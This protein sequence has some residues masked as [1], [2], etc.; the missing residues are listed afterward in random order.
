MQFFCLHILN[1]QNEITGG[2]FLATAKLGVTAA[3]CL[4]DVAIEGEEFWIECPKSGDK[5]KAVVREIDQQ[6]DL[7]VIELLSV[8]S[9]EIPPTGDCEAGAAWNS[10][11]RPTPYDS[12]LNGNVVRCDLDYMLNTGSAIQGLQLNENGRIGDYRGYSGGPIEVSQGTSHHRIVGVLLEQ[13]EDR[14]EDPS[15]VASDTRRAT[16]VL[17]AARMLDVRQL[18]VFQNG[19]LRVFASVSGD[20]CDQAAQRL[21]I[22]RESLAD[23][24]AL[25]EMLKE[26]SVNGGFPGFD[27]TKARASIEGDLRVVFGSG[28]GGS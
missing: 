25:L 3:H 26:L 4:D 27:L 13:H 5:L 23:G 8:S 12:E 14:Y 21:R 2:G 1:A 24:Q 10:S 6:Q 20:Q 18:R 15:T 7:A 16:G 22:K 11:Y 28:N 9:C 19:V 17:V